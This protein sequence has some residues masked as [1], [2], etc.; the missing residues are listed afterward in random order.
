MINISIIVM[1]SL[2][3]IWDQTRKNKGVGPANSLKPYR[4]YWKSVATI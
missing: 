3:H 1:L 4:S 2:W